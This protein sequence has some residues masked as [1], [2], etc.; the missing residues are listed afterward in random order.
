M[1]K[2]NKFRRH[3][4]QGGYPK[5]LLKNSLEE[6]VNSKNLNIVVFSCLNSELVLT[7]KKQGYN[8]KNLYY[9]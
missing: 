2:R 3:F 6:Q 1:D 7:V 4:H 8:H 5:I 9:E